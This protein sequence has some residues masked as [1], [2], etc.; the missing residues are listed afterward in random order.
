MSETTVKQ[1]KMGSESNLPRKVSETPPSEISSSQMVKNSNQRLRRGSGRTFIDKSLLSLTYNNMKFTAPPD[2]RELLA[3][4]TK[5]V[6]EDQ[7]SNIPLYL[8]RYFK[9]LDKDN[10][11]QKQKA[12]IQA[13]K[14]EIERIE[15]ERIKAEKQAAIKKR[16][17]AMK[18]RQQ[19]LAIMK[20][21]ILAE[22]ERQRQADEKELQDNATFFAEEI[23]KQAYS[24][25][26]EQILREN[27]KIGLLNLEEKKSV[28]LTEISDK[29]ETLENQTEYLD[30]CMD[31]IYNHQIKVHEESMHQHQLKIQEYTSRLVELE[32]FIEKVSGIVEKL[33][34]AKPTLVAEREAYVQ[35]IERLHDVKH[36]LVKDYNLKIIQLE[37]KFKD[38]LELIHKYLT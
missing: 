14:D 22:A 37:V 6:L 3:V 31:T 15:K 38:E 8:A 7:P 2:F 26:K 20:A 27:H 16:Q 12:R 10:V 24:I 33:N 29:I 19:K 9:E 13:E 35:K 21:N 32:E 11:Y 28:A 23:I 1:S 30:D 5:T 18:A 36:D 4:L 25:R 17:A 34:E